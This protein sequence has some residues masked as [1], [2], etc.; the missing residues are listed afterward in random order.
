VTDD[1]WSMVGT[2]N[3]DYRSLFTNY[4]L[5]LVTINQELASKLKQQFIEDLSLSECISLNDWKK[6]DGLSRW[7][8]RVAMI[9]K[10]WL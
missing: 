6:R 1:H 2:S 7:Q 4:E 5:N 8:G 9:L 3:L 10:R